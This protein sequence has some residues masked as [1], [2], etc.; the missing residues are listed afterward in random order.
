[1]YVL[2]K[3]YIT[4]WSIILGEREIIIKITHIVYQRMCMDEE[5]TYGGEI[6]YEVK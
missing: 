1:M 2:N 4:T 5:N 3:T 6:N